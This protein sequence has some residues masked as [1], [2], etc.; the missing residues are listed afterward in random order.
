MLAL[1]IFQM[2]G[3]KDTYANN[4]P[5]MLRTKYFHHVLEDL[6][7]FWRDISVVLHF[8]GFVRQTVLK[9][10]MNLCGPNNLV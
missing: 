4:T 8:D 3:V 1:K 2:N 10:P 9:I 6:N 5:F 7:L